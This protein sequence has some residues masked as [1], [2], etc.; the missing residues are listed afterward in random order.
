MMPSANTPQNPDTT[1]GN[2]PAKPAGA[3]APAAPAADKAKADKAAADKAKADKAAADKAAADKAAADKAVAATKQERK[4]LKALANR[5]GQKID[6]AFK[7]ADGFTFLQRGHALAHAR[8]LKD[9][10]IIKINV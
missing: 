4:D 9:D 5:T 10:T 3:P 1:A 6:H 7:T 8:T 2:S